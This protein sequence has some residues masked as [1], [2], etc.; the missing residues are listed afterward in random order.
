MVN[1][2]WMTLWGKVVMPRSADRGGAS[3]V[4]LDERCGNR[5]M[6]PALERVT[7]F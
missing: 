3:R 6:V 4:P 7:R 5:F 2:E 1:K